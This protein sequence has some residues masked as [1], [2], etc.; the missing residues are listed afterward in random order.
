MK[1]PKKLTKIDM[2]IFSKE[3]R[4]VG[5]RYY[6]TDLGWAYFTDGRPKHTDVVYH[7]DRKA[8]AWRLRRMRGEAV[9]K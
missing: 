8:L 4:L 1:W 2:D 5:G 7:W 6:D 9:S 3:W